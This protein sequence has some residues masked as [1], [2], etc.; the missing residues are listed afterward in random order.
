[1]PFWK[2]RLLTQLTRIERHRAGL[3][4][5]SSEKQ[6]APSIDASEPGRVDAAIAEVTAR[7]L[8]SGAP[9]SL[10]EWAQSPRGAEWG[11]ERSAPAD[12]PEPLLDQVAADHNRLDTRWRARADPKIERYCARALQEG[13]P[14]AAGTAI[15]PHSVAPPSLGR[16]LRTAAQALDTADLLAPAPGAA[17]TAAVRDLVPATGTG[18]REPVWQDPGGN[19]SSSGEGLE[20]VRDAERGL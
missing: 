13:M 11:G 9:P 17:I 5:H 7:A 6:S 4:P 8:V 10:L 15:R 12:A 14:V 19:G 18:T 3:E 16:M 2:R 20:P 1:M